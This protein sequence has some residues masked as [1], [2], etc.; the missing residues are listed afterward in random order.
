MTE[1]PIGADS[2]AGQKGPP[3]VSTESGPLIGTRTGSVASFKGIPFA[4]PPVGPRRWRPP[5]PAPGWSEPLAV[6]AFA[7]A[8]IQSQPAR[9][10]V[11]FQTNFAD[12]RA[13]VM[14]EDC[15]Y[16]NVWTPEPVADA[17]L[18]VMVW[19]HG[20]GN[21]FG[22]GG[23]EIHDGAAIAARG[24]V[25]VT[26]NYRLGALG[27]LA[28]P[29]LAAEDDL[30]A[31]GNYGLLDVVAALEWVRTNIADF[32]GDP[33]QVTIAG[34]SAGAAMI[35]HLMA[36][37]GARGLFRAA[38]GQS[39]AGIFRAEGSMPTQL[40]AQEDG[41]AAIERLGCTS[42]GQLRERSAT[43][44]LLPAH[45]GIV[46]DGR[47]IQRDTQDVFVAGEQAAVPLLV[48]SNSD[49]GVI[50]TPSTAAESL[51]RRVELG[52]AELTDVYPVDPDRVKASA[53]AFT[54]ESRFSYPVWRWARTH[55]ETTRAPTWMYRFE[56]QPPLPD[57]IGLLPPADGEPGYGVFHTAELPYTGGN[58][59]ARDW[60]WRDLDRHLAAVIGDTWARFVT[61]MDPNG[62]GL[63]DWRQFSAARE[64]ELMEYGERIGM[65]GV[66]RLEAMALLDALPR[67][68]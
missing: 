9:S 47:L 18:P 35:T 41:T 4:A 64:A 63:P 7:P 36:A 34:N 44:F 40:Q 28:L 23:Q 45:L 30:G 38:I 61:A 37:P 15:L 12:H 65:R 43:E 60:A 16:L 48:G 25:V 19:L 2:R 24:I 66:P 58:L 11:M 46:V 57:D 55:V 29:E 51:K 20:G 27:F 13:L 52:P 59:W 8:P 39:S 6:Q 68:L 33:S 22:H 56:H 42:P 21:R 67:P 3:R 26:L 49:E 54:G 10:S 32:G 17:G 50:Y 5:A 1:P 62:P 53:R 14:S 31:S